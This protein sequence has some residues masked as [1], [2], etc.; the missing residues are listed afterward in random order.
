MLLYRS[1]AARFLRPAELSSAC[2]RPDAAA[3]RRAGPLTRALGLRALILALLLTVGVGM[4]AQAQA[5]DTSASAR[6]DTAAIEHPELRRELVA[7]ART[8][9]KVRKTLIAN[10]GADGV[11][12]SSDLARMQEIDATN[13]ERLKA[14]VD[15]H[16]WPTPAQV[17]REGADAAVLLLLHAPDLDFKRRMLPAAKAEF[18][19]GRLAGEKYALLVDKVRVAS[20]EPQVY[21]TQMKPVS[22]W[23]DGEPVPNPI[24]DRATLDER[25]AEVG[26]PPLKTYLKLVKQM[27]EQRQ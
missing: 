23:T 20:G 1:F 19:A 21:G 2:S 7:M 25:R 4:E 26:L 18:E 9:Q 16:G 3:S 12:D 6:A 5:P 17:G 15:Q 27:Y 24:E 11:P 13:T 8:D 14:I 22:T 10:M